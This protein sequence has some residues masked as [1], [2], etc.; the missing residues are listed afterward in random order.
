MTHH[1]GERWV[2]P[3]KMGFI[4][5]VADPL[6][7]HMQLCSQTHYKNS[8]VLEEKSIIF[9]SRCTGLAIHGCQFLQ[10]KEPCNSECPCT[11][12]VRTPINC[13]TSHTVSAHHHEVFL[14]LTPEEWYPNTLGHYLKFFPCLSNYLSTLPQQAQTCSQQLKCHRN[15]LI[16]P[17]WKVLLLHFKLLLVPNCIKI[18]KPTHSPTRVFSITTYHHQ[19]CVAL[20]APHLAL[21]FTDRV[22]FVTFYKLF[23][24]SMQKLTKW[25]LSGDFPKNSH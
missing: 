25:W 5:P 17:A 14:H 1:F 15:A 4:N 10:M 20:L 11:A 16:K 19:Q 12:L 21:L 3:S 24:Q 22:T 7:S 18:C 6:T 8:M 2:Q 23:L 9:H 13:L